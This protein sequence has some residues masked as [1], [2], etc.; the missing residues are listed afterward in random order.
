VALPV[1]FQRL[2]SAAVAVLV[3]V[4]FVQLG[5]AWWWLLAVFLLWDLSMVGYLV[6]PEVGAISY[7]IGHSYL[8]PALLALTWVV[9]GDARWPIF[10]ALTWAFHIAVDRLLGYGL[11]F[12]DRFTHTH[13]GEVGN[14]R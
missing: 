6:S 7:N 2:E 3:V 13:L 12:T 8:G 9:A 10:V 5:F 11:K 14:K 1:W 4:A